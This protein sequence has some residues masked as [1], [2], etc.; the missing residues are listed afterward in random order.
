[1][2]SVLIGGSL[3]LIST[4]CTAAFFFVHALP[5][6]LLYAVPAAATGVAIEAF[7]FY[8]PT[9]LSD[10]RRERHW[11]GIKRTFQ[12]LVA[13]SLIST[14]MTINWL[15]TNKLSTAAP[16]QVAGLQSRI[17]GLEATIADRSQSEEIMR[18]EGFA[19]RANDSSERTLEL[20]SELADLKPKLVISEGS[21]K[22][23]VAT[24]IGWVVFAIVAVFIEACSLYGLVPRQ[25]GNPAKS[26][27]PFE[28][29]EVRRKTK[30]SKKGSGNPDRSA[31]NPSNK[32]VPGPLPGN[33]S[34]IA[35]VDPAP[36]VDPEFQTRVDKARRAILNRK[37][38]P[39]RI[40]I[41][42]LIKCRGSTATEILKALKEDGSIDDVLAEIAK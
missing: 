33:V 16:A 14:W 24:V 20:R 2:I 41:K 31:G 11:I 15:E 19:T 12:G 21:Q 23:I 3:A 8:A 6:G 5:G 28:N 25:N 7:K 38:R 34:P 13:I 26:A 22:G 4:A 37:I 35:K 32:Q 42:E 39:M 17:S 9:M 27:G 18:A 40:D 10:K 29:K 30:S 36:T 1:M